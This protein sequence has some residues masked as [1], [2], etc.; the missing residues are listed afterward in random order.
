MVINETKEVIFEQVSSERVGRHR[1][2]LGNASPR[3]SVISQWECCFL[4][5]ESIPRA[6]CLFSCHLTE[7]RVPVSGG[8]TDSERKRR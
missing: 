1:N 8:T 3:E 4:N 7:H 2:R 5:T 6:E